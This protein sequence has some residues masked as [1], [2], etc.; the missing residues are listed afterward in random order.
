M[1]KILNYIL[2]E[3]EENWTICSATDGDLKSSKKQPYYFKMVIKL[4]SEEGTLKTE[5]T[6]IAQIFNW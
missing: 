3:I 6:E 4:V 2:L 5:I 1:T